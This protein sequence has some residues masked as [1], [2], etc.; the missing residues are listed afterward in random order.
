MELKEFSALITLRA[1]N[2]EDFKEQLNSLDCYELEWW[3][4]GSK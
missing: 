4:G 3:K 2:E 1:Y